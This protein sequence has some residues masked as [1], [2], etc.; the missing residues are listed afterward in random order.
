MAQIMCFAEGSLTGMACEAIVRGFDTAGVMADM[1]FSSPATDVLDVGSDLGNSEVMDSFLNTSN[2]TETGMVTE[3]ALRQVY[4]AYSYTS[5]RMLTERWHE[6]TSRM[7]F[8]VYVWH[9]CND[10]HM[11]LRR[12]VLGYSKARKTQPH[13]READFDEVFD[14][15]FHTTGFSRPLKC[16]CNGQP[17]GELVQQLL[18]SSKASARLSKLWYYLS[19]GPLEYASKG[20]VDAQV[21]QELGDTLCKKRWR[22]LMPWVS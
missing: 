22:T 7:S 2:F 3:D 4:E 16:A 13:Q 9:M 19:T 12:T 21:E 14:D 15:D 10:R 11:F 5:A 20:I 17:L 8:Q 18:D 1:V 6:P